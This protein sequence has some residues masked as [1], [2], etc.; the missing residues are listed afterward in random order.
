MSAP[1]PAP[2]GDRLPA[3]YGARAAVGDDVQALAR[4]FIAEQLH[5]AIFEAESA[6][7]CTEIA[8]DCGLR[9]HVR[10]MAAH[11]RQVIDATNEL[12]R[13]ISDAPAVT[14]ESAA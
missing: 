3:F 7:R 9:Y 5:A 13:P 6:W 8:D 10:R 14:R 12:R 1:R 4:E 2:D 11:V